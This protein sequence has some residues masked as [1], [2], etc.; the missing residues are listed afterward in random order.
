VGLT[1]TRELIF[2]ID[3]NGRPVTTPTNEDLTAVINIDPQVV[4]KYHKQLYLG[5]GFQWI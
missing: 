5:K 1:L 2:F 4:W 3:R